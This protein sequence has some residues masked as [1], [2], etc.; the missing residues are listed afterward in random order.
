MDDRL[1]CSACGDVVGVFERAIAYTDGEPRVTS[2]TREPHLRGGP[3]AVFHEACAP[4]PA[5]ARR[6]NG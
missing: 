2:V 3:G 5:P 4:R 1:R 6:T